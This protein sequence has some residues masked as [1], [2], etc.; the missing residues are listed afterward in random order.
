[1]TPAPLLIVHRNTDAPEGHQFIAGFYR[2]MMKNGAQVGIARLP[3][4][5][6]ASTRERVTSAANEWWQSEQDKLQRQRDNAVAA[7]ERRRKSA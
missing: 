1:M 6:E 5:F 2:P 7:S 3:I 4:I